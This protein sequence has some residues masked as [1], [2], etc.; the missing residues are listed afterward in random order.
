MP[1]SSFLHGYDLRHVSVPTSFPF[2]LVGLALGK[3]NAPV[4]VLVAISSSEPRLPMLRS[5]WKE[6]NAGR[7]APLLLIVLYDSKAAICGATGDDPPAYVGIDPGQ[8]ERICKEALEQP[9]RHAALRTLRD[10]LPAV[11]SELA[12]L[13]NE[14]FLATHE[15]LTGVRKRHDWRTAG[16][17]AKRII[18]NRGEELLKTT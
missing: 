9:D 10:S 17:K 2:N 8:V 4:E 12:G 6:R 1:D 15:L 13:C 7:P 18:S 16:E 3:G 11:K 5:C 14:G